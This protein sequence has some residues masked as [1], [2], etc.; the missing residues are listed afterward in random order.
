MFALADRAN[1]LGSKLFER[2]KGALREG[3]DVND[4]SLMFELIAAVKLRDRDRTQALRRRYLAILLDG[5]RA[6]DRDRLPASAPSWQEV[7]ERWA[8][9]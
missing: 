5:L 3:A 1:Q 9:D 2:V 4:V 8:T 6:T 7:S